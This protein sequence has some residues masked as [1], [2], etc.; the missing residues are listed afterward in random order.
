[1]S[2]EGAHGDTR[3]PKETGGGLSERTATPGYPF[4]ESFAPDAADRRSP[5]SGDDSKQLQAV[6]QSLL[7]RLRLPLLLDHILK[8][9]D[10]SEQHAEDL[11]S[12]LLHRSVLER[13][14]IRSF[15]H[16]LYRNC[17][18]LCDKTTQLVIPATGVGCHHSHEI[19]ETVEETSGGHTNEPGPPIGPGLG[20]RDGGRAAAPGISD[21]VLGSDAPPGE[22]GNGHG[23]GNHRGTDQQPIHTLEVDK[24]SQEASRG[25]CS[26][27]PRQSTRVSE[28][29]DASL[30]GGTLVAVSPRTL[31]SASKRLPAASC[32]GP[33]VGAVDRDQYCLHL[34]DQTLQDFISDSYEEVQQL[35]L[36]EN[37]PGT[38]KALF[39]ALGS[40]DNEDEAK[41]SDGSQWASLVEAANGERHRGS[42]R[43]A[44]TATA[45]A[46]WH[47]SQVRLLGG[48]D[49]RT[50]AK[51]VSARILGPRPQDCTADKRWEQRRKSLAAHLSR[52]RKWS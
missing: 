16:D 50:A 42:I 17:D 23:Q 12:S 31:Q 24:R 37:L 10:E 6:A 15:A 33:S 44:L 41:W 1:M 47:A 3:N 20:P 52:G 43:Y 49:A 8:T 11:R 51:R 27:P 34:L 26:T 22:E 13:L 39:D 46:R 29:S 30:A 28:A 32:I 4:A 9:A 19:I 38:Y 45:F 2:S 25:L 7:A 14:R 40:R 35:G 18:D 48:I 36:Q 21:E 5:Y